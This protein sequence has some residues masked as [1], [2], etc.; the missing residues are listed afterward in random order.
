MDIV[1]I[2]AR[3][4][5]EKSLLLAQ[6]SRKNLSTRSEPNKEAS[7]S[8]PITEDRSS[9][10]VAEI[11]A[12]RNLAQVERCLALI[13]SGMFGICTE[14]G[15]EISEARLKLLHADITKCVTCADKRSLPALTFIRKPE[16][17]RR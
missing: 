2:R 7:D 16:R 6:V 5:N 9:E 10:A 17:R 1:S 13:E 11:L 14:C 8:V 12:K 3:L 15:E 4:Q